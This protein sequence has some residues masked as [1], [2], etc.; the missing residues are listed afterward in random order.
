MREIDRKI[1]DRCKRCSSWGCLSDKEFILS[2][3]LRQVFRFG[4]FFVPFLIPVGRIFM[5]EIF[6]FSNLYVLLVSVFA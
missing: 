4:V 3:T 5:F 6:K 1:I 2:L